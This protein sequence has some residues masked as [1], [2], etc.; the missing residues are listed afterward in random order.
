MIM[1]LIQ[2]FIKS[3]KSRSKIPSIDNKLHHSGFPG[4]IGIQGPFQCPSN[5]SWMFHPFTMAEAPIPQLQRANEF[6]KKMAQKT[7]G[8]FTAMKVDPA[9]K[10]PPDFH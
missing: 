10:P 7:G 2:S 9:E 5:I 8:T 4:C 1:R 3:L 6:L